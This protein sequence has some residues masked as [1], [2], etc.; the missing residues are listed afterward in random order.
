MTLEVFRSGHLKSWVRL[1]EEIL[2]RSKTKIEIWWL[3]Y[4]S[5]RF[6][7]ISKRFEMLELHYPF[8]GI[9]CSFHVVLF[10]HLGMK[11]KIEHFSHMLTTNLVIL[12]YLKLW[13]L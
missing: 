6:P 8:I 12:S 10:K 7:A 5:Y 4:S 1:V 11:P 9:V 2:G 13:C 3:S